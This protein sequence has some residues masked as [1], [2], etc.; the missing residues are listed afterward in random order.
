MS[1][2]T[3]RGG[4]SLGVL[5]LV[6]AG[7]AQTPLAPTVAFAPG[8]GKTAAALQADQDACKATAAS[9]AQGAGGSGAGLQS[10]LQGVQQAFGGSTGQSPA[11]AQQQF[12][13]VFAACMTQ[14]GDVPATGTASATPAMPARPQPDPLVR[15]VQTELIRLHYL[16]DTADGLMGPK[17]AAAL[18][19]FE[20]AGSLPTEPRPSPHLLAVLQSTPTP[21][22]SVPAASVPAASVPAAGAPTAGSSGW[23]DPSS[24]SDA[25]Q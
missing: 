5:A 13:A 4:R 14:K 15:A 12:D 8:P 23:I 24:P 21:A 10:A 22:A 2:Q 11:P 16:A 1:G 6:L 25:A 3:W 20:Q 19:A 7:C 18:R 17:T 9:A